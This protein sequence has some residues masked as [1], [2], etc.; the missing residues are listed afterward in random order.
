MTF[1]MKKSQKVFFFSI[2]VTRSKTRMI[3]QFPQIRLC[4]VAIEHNR[5]AER[6]ALLKRNILINRRKSID[7]LVKSKPK[8]GK[9]V[10]KRRHTI[11]KWNSEVKCNQV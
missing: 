6:L 2:S 11:G 10:T 4:Y 8:P 3:A 5:K 7:V 1:I 9:P